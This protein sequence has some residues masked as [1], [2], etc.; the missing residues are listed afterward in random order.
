MNILTNEIVE[1]N[2][3]ETVLDFA[4]QHA[5]T[6]AQTVLPVVACVPKVSF[7]YVSVCFC[8]FLYAVSPFLLFPP[9]FLAQSN[10]CLF[11]SST[12]VN[13]FHRYLYHASSC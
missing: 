5:S 3:S 9:R 7:L 13:N 8:M 10:T 6:P 12:Y 11:L 4:R 1:N 2:N